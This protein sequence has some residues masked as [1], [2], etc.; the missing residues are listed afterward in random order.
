MAIRWGST[1]HF[2]APALHRADRPRRVLKHG[3][4]MIARPKPILE[5]E[6]RHA[7]RVEPLRNL[8]SLVIHGQHSVAA[9]RANDHGRTRGRLRPGQPDRQGG[10]VRLGIVPLRPRCPAG[11]EGH[12]LVL[13]HGISADPRGE[14]QHNQ[15]N[16]HRGSSLRFPSTITRH[17]RLAY[18]IVPPPLL[19][20]M[21]H[22]P[23]RLGIIGGLPPESKQQGL[24]WRNLGPA[25]A[26]LTL[27]L[28]VYDF[29]RGEHLASSDP[30]CLILPRCSI[31][32]SP[33]GSLERPESMKF[34]L[35]LVLVGIG[36]VALAVAVVSWIAGPSLW[37]RFAPW[38][39]ANQTTEEEKAPDPNREYY[40]DPNA[41]GTSAK[42]FVDRREIDSDVGAAML[43]YRGTIRDTNSLQELR[44]AMRGRGRRSLADLR[45]KFDQLKLGSSPSFDNRLIAMRLA[46]QIAFTYMYD[47]KLAEASS[48]LQRGMDFSLTA[49][50]P[51]DLPRVFELLLGVASLREGEVE[52]CLECCGPSSCIFP[53]DLEA[54]HRQQSGSRKAI[55]YFTDYLGQEPG[56]LRARWLLNVAYMTLGE[57][58]DRVPREY[59]IPLDPFRSEIN[60]GRFENVAPMAG[61]NVRGPNLA[62]GNIF[63]DFNNDGLPD[64]FITSIDTEQ[65]A[66]LFINKGDGTFED[67]SSWA[68]L[69]DQ[70]YALNLCAPTLTT[71]A[72][73]TSC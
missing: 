56:D 11:P 24:S 66:A 71:T 61:L 55:G 70:V 59:L 8:L 17:D 2:P 21:I 48:W 15:G 26:G 46:Q 6:G 14:H 51:K 50:M 1:P 65:G 16:A 4:V 53:I 40:P 12:N 10:D 42:V 47:G 60:I 29:F 34:F 13:R 28:A 27:I 22:A 9:A 5:H 64:I 57:Y 32:V 63:D 54:Q 58:P 25:P 31:A 30:G 38:V 3:R 23:L 41:P 43:Y 36:C 72:T 7:Q 67:R 62:G 69:G 20:V 73:W 35:R 18:P 68:N 52:N 39:P 33:H 37:A 44:D 19:D 49:G 45:R